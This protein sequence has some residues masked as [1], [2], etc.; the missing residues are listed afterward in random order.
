MIS[1]ELNEDRN[2]HDIRIWLEDHVGWIINYD[3]QGYYEGIGWKMNVIRP[4]Y[5]Q[6]HIEIDIEFEDPAMETWFILRWA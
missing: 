4:N 3:N 6:Y 2:L 5:G 1:L